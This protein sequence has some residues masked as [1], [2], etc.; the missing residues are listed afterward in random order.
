MS[1]LSKALHLDEVPALR[2]TVDLMLHG[3][4]QVQLY[5][6]RIAI[7]EAMI[8]EGISKEVADAVWYK[9]LKTLGIG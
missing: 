4:I 7:E 9:S 2:H 3:M 1:K 6:V 8:S 5:E